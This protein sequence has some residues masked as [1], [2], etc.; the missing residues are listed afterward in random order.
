MQ[1][2]L[3]SLNINFEGVDN[4][5]IIHIKRDDD[6][7]NKIDED[8]EIDINENEADFF[9]IIDEDIISNSGRLF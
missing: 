9:N 2:I 5:H 6:I 7:N 3:N 4:K 1:R 8:I